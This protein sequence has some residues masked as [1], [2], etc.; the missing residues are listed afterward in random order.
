MKNAK[1]T[2][3][4]LIIVVLLALPFTLSTLN[5]KALQAT[6]LTFEQNIYTDSDITKNEHYQ[7]EDSEDEN[8]SAAGPELEREFFTKWHEPYGNM[9]EPAVMEDIQSQIK[10]IP[11]EIDY[12]N[13]PINSW[14][15]IGPY[16]MNVTY[17]GGVRYSGRIL[18]IE[19]P[20]NGASIRVAGASGGIWQFSSFFPFS[21]LGIMNTTTTQSTSTFVTKPGDK[22]TI[23]VGTGEESQ[24]T[25]TGLWRT[26]NEGTSWT[27][28]PIS[29]TP[30]AFNKI[31]Y[32][33]GST[34]IIHAVTDVGYFQSTDGG[35][36]WTRKFTGNITDVSINPANTNDLYITKWGDS[37]TGGIY[38]TNNAGLSWY[39][40]ITPG[41]P[42]TNV[43]RSAITECTSSPYI[44]YV[45]ITRNDNNAPMGIYK[46]VNW[47][48][49][50]TN[51][52]PSLTSLGGNGWYNAVIGV[53]PTDPNRVL[54]GMTNLVITGNGGS[55]WSQITDHNV[56][57]DIHAITWE[58]NGTTVYCGNDGG[59]STSN[60]VGV[61][62]NNT[63]NNFGITQYYHC[64][65]GIADNQFICGGSQDNGLSFTTN[66]GVSGWSH[67]L[68]GDGGGVSFDPTNSTRIFAVTGAYGGSIKF[69]RQISNNSGQSWTDFNNGISEDSNWT[70][71]IRTDREIPFKVYTNANSF[72]Y[73]SQ[74]PY[75]SWSKLNAASFPDLVSNVTVTSGGVVFACLSHGSG[76]AQLRV[77]EN[78]TWYER[79]A[80]LPSYT[81]VRTVTHITTGF[82]PNFITHSYAVMNG[83]GT[84]GQKI[85]RSTNFGLTW[86]NITGDL[87]NVP[88]GD[89]VRHPTNPSIL[90]IGTEFGCYKTSNGGANWV[91]WNNGMPDANIV[92]EMGVIDSLS[93]SG[94]YYV[95]AA[96]FGR[97]VWI[98]DISGDDP[99]TGVKDNSNEI[100]NKFELQ[101]NFPNPFNPST[102]IKFGIPKSSHVKISIYDITGKLIETLIDKDMTAS[103]YEI[104][105]NANNYSSGVYFYRLDT[106]GFSDVKK[107][108]L[109]K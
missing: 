88:L 31:R 99:M 42:T 59:L 74:S 98:R 47:G 34:T 80:G 72:V 38:A 75:S 97:G 83:L 7:K 85:F 6:M 91:R 92:T 28:I 103:T 51:V 55:S 65:V 45:L 58:S 1:K 41:I 37:L 22:R 12:R 27:N 21:P 106:E 25:G 61:S 11:T 62:W 87:P 33:P 70:P 18:D 69:R 36:S 77:Y 100:A 57:A 14:S 93:T 109:V 29:P 104:T 9:L 81:P 95:L 102:S 68:G 4:F 60:D 78:G 79:S 19:P 107:M 82:F 96:T 86:A 52:S 90:Y 30:S 2:T 8:E 89:L 13:L 26:T 43:G 24:R 63:N 3:T 71:V 32:S 76:G 35:S 23:F 16:G 15:N 10:K 101:Q 84:P 48:S 108:I 56:H 67:S 40:I 50:W 46:T 39:K 17:E 64:S 5:N 49:S 66:G 94:K 105:W 20:Q 44:L 53:S 54:A 73:Y